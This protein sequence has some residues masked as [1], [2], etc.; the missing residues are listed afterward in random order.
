[1]SNKSVFFSVIYF[2]MVLFSLGPLGLR[3]QEL[4]TAHPGNAFYTWL[5]AWAPGLIL[6]T[7]F[8]VLGWGASRLFKR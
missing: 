4:A 6:I 3:A 8:I 2:M 7:G 1:M 5:A